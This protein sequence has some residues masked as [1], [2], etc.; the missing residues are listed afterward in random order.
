MSPELQIT[1]FEWGK[2]GAETAI[3][4][5][6]C[7][8][9]RKAGNVKPIFCSTGEALW[10]EQIRL[11]NRVVALFTLEGIEMPEDMKELVRTRPE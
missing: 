4:I 1:I 9:C 7:S 6:A 10:R 3:H 11:E 5:R 2:L 8:V